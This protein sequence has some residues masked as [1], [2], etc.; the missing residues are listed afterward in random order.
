MHVIGPHHDDGSEGTL[1]F[2]RSNIS[3]YFKRK[4]HHA[5]LASSQ[6]KHDDERRVDNDSRNQQQS[7]D[8]ASSFSETGKENKSS[9]I[10]TTSN[11]DKNLYLHDQQ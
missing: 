3:S 11:G 2:A 1:P 4:E 8:G 10:R 5:A 9:V 7:N 6:M